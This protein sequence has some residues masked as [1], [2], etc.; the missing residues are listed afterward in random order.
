MPSFVLLNQNTTIA[1]T[2]ENTDI[3]HFRKIMLL[4]LHQSRTEEMLF[5]QVTDYGSGGSGFLA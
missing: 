3:I 4:P 2:K 1:I 5:L